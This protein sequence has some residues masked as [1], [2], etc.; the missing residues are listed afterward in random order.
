MCGDFVNHD[1]TVTFL[2]LALQQ[3][4]STIGCFQQ[5]KL[6]SCP[7]AG[8]MTNSTSNNCTGV[9]FSQG[10][11]HMQDL[12]GAEETYVSVHGGSDGGARVAGRES[13]PHHRKSYSGT[14]SDEEGRPTRSKSGSEAV[15]ATARDKVSQ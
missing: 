13:W 15:L 7:V 14:V 9:S 11:R 1:C 10:R 2:A 8:Q 3:V 4:A 12:A 6:S 5:G